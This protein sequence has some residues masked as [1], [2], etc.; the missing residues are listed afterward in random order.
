MVEET[1][2][3]KSYI[4]NASA[5][6]FGFE[7]KVFALTDV[8]VYIKDTETGV[9]TIPVLDTDYTIAAVGGDLD[10]G[11]NVTTIGSGSPLSATQ[12]ITIVRS[13]DE[14]QLLDLEE[15]GD[16]PANELEDALDRNTIISQQISDDGGRHI[17]CPVTDP[18]DS[19]GADTLNY[20]LPTVEKRAGK[21]L[22]F[23][24]DGSVAVASIATE[25]G[26]FTAVNEDRGLTASGGTISAKVDDDTIE[27]SSGDIAVKAQ[28]IGDTE[29]EDSSITTSKLASKTGADTTVVTGTA[30]A[31]G[32][33][34]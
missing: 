31:G 21:A 29:L 27:F 4:G 7:T 16:L 15:G 17:G 6:I 30:G 1:F 23:S 18:V 28:G 2:N 12:Q 10:N 22:V 20:E 13:I 26:A 14:T 9:V 33:G 32:R 25:G 24:E 8:L 34:V 11:V 19:S 3:R 5:T